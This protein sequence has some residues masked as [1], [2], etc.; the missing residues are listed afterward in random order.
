MT[1]ATVDSLLKGLGCNMMAKSPKDLF[2]E[3]CLS[4][5]S[6]YVLQDPKA[7]VLLVGAMMT[8][9]QILHPEFLLKTMKNRKCDS[10]VIGALLLKM[11]DRR[12]GKVIDFC[13]QQNFKSETPSKILTLALK[14]GQVGADPEFGSFGIEISQLDKVDQKKIANVEHFL[15]GNLF[16]RNRLLFGCNWRADIIS[17]IELGVN[18]PTAVKNRLHC[19]YETAH[20]VFN[21]YRLVANA[22]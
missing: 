21:E 18:N 20:R 15:R 14:I 1:L 6:L 2:P 11:R 3:E 8:H 12:F 10:N 13:H 9:I 7:L 4:E 5:L 22:I 16:V 17:T 19:S